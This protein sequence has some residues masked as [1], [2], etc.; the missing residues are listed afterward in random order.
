MKRRFVAGAVC[1]ACQEVDRLVLEY[2][3]DQPEPLRRVCV[4]CGFSE[5]LEGTSAGIGGVPPGKFEK[6]APATTATQADPVRIID[7]ASD[8]PVQVDKP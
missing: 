3:N 7:F 1:P 4:A 8:K 5:D 6:P 2:D